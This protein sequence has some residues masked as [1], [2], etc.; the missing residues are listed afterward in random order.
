[1]AVPT[2]ADDVQDDVAVEFHPEFRR[3]AGAEDHRFR[4]VAINVQNGRLDRL[5]D[6]GAIQARVGVRRDGGEA[7][8]VVDDQVDGAACAVADQLAHRQG[9]VN[10]ALTREGRIAVHQQRHDRGAGLGVARPILAGTDLAD[11]DGIDGFQ[12]R[13]IRL[14]R[15]M[16]AVSVD[17]EVGGGS[18]MVFHVP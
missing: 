4:V 17:F 13:R 11:N 9:F 5:G 1:M 2:V 18:E 10:Q 14:E 3:H 7:D 15:H 8:L 12:M 16:D 6:V